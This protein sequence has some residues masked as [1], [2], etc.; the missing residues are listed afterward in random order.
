MVWIKYKF[1]SKKEKNIYLFGFYFILLITPTF[2]LTSN[3]L[4]FYYANFIYNYL[5]IVSNYLDKVLDSYTLNGLFTL[6]NTLVLSFISFVV[7]KKINNRVFF[8]RS[9]IF[10]LILFYL[11]MFLKI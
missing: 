9:Y 6:L 11:W 7:Y 10:L 3:Y 2:L 4:M 5:P 8:W 1:P